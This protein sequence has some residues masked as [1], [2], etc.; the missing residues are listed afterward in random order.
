MKINFKPEDR[1]QVLQKV[2]E[3][4]ALIEERLPYLEPNTTDFNDGCSLYAQAAITKAFI[5][6]QQEN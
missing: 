4:M 1:A 6:S 2:E 3:M 5:K